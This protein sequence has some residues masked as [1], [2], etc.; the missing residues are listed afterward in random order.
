[1]EVKEVEQLQPII[2]LSLKSTYGEHIQDIELLRATQIPILD[3]EK[4]LWRTSV[5]FNNG[6][7]KYEVSIDIRIA[8]GTV[9]RTEEIVKQPLT[10]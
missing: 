8:D 9:K 3:E 1:M 6:T 4:E 2:E 5:E 7:T 10:K